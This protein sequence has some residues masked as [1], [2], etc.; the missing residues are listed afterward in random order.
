MLT[1]GVSIFI[2][3]SFLFFYFFYLFIFYISYF[4]HSFTFLL[5][6]YDVNLYI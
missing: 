1:M 2:L 5:I 4:V 3:S 6:H